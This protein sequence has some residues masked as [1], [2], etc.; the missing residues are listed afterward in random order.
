MSKS[1]TTILIIDDHALVRRGLRL[2]LDSHEGLRVVGEAGSLPEAIEI[3]GDLRP[4]IIT[5][6]LSMPGAAG[7]ASVDRLRRASPGSRIVVVSM[8]DEPP[9]VCSARALGAS[10]FVTKSAADAE[11]VNTVRTVAR[12]E[13]FVAVLAEQTGAARPSTCKHLPGNSPA[14]QLSDREMQVLAAVAQGYSNQQIADR[15]C[16][17][18]KTVESNRAR[19]M[20]KLDLQDRADLVQVAIGLGLLSRPGG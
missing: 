17:S 20:Q 13:G 15:M 4:H 1:D 11:L 5:L 9:Y 7:I 14:S 19:L 18:V 16:L 6:D 2:V 10:G 8:H 12:G 3:I